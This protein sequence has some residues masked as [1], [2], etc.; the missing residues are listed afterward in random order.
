[1]DVL[2]GKVVPVKLGFIA[3]M[4]RSQQVCAHPYR[5][6][7]WMEVYMNRSQQVCAYPYRRFRLD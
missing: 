6:F 7:V 2:T 1:M 3:V 5:R 4:N